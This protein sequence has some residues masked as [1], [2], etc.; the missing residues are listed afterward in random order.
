MGYF[1]RRSRFVL[2][3]VLLLAS[4]GIADSQEG[5]VQQQKRLSDDSGRAQ[6]IDSVLAKVLW[7]AVRASKAVVPSVVF[8]SVERDAAGETPT[9][10]QDLFGY[11]FDYDTPTPETQAPP[12]FGSGSGFV[13]DDEGHIITNYHV[14]AEA[15]LVEVRAFNGKKFQAEVVGVDP[16][17]DIA[18][19]HVADHDGALFPAPIGESEDLAIGDKVLALGN[20]LGLGFTIT[21]GTVLTKGGQLTGWESTVEAFIRTNAAINPGNSGGPLLDLSG[22][23]VG[24][25][26]AIARSNHFVS[27]GFAV[28]MSLALEVIDDLLEYGYVRR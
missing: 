19:L 22:R 26:T 27:F 5:V 12:G 17:T 3:L 13:L 2:P 4:P 9:Q 8:V 10:I 21:L 7:S 6:E 20:P 28:P 24:I 14:V 25:N 18:L 16:V 1:D 11:F 23:V 15:T